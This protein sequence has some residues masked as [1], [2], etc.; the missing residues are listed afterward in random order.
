M[1]H[2]ETPSCMWQDIVF[3]AALLVMSAG[4]ESADIVSGAWDDEYNLL[5][6]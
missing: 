2:Y 1:K 6:D 3:S 4:A 5:T